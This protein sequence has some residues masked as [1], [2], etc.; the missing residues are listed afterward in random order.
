LFFVVERRRSYR[1]DPAPA[2]RRPAARNSLHAARAGA[3]KPLFQKY[4][5]RHGLQ[6][7]SSRDG[8]IGSLC[9]SGPRAGPVGLCS[10]IATNFREFLQVTINLRKILQKSIVFLPYCMNNA[11][12]TGGIAGCRQIR[13]ENTTNLFGSRVA[14]GIPRVFAW[15]RRVYLLVVSELYFGVFPSS[16]RN[17]IS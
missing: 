16:D 15:Q 4:Q 10:K 8:T 7:A 11:Q 5:D 12:P 6:F 17:R 3:I 9:H 13:W 14:V 2:R 1:A